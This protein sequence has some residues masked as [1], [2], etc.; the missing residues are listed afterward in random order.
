MIYYTGAIQ[1]QAEQPSAIKSL[2]GFVS[3]T[4]VP[5]DV[6]NNLFPVIDI[7]TLT[8]KTKHIRVIAFKNETENKINL[9][10]YTE[11]Q[12]D[13]ISKLNIGLIKQSTM[14]DAC[15]T[16]YFET[17]PNG[18]SKPIYVELHNAEGE[19]NA[20]E[21]TDIN[22]GEYVGVFI[23]REII[24]ENNQDLLDTNGNF[25]QK[26]CEDFYIE[27]NENNGEEF[28][29]QPKT[30]NIEIVFDFQ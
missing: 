3:S 13:S 20:V 16:P 12:A 21:I 23:Q 2:G 10:V 30:D 1:N 6:M 4:H 8:N 24:I 5:N 26:S 29:I 25:K 14:S 11:S 19:L 28:I 17:L 27:Y 18:I 9:K 15:L 22:A 7:S